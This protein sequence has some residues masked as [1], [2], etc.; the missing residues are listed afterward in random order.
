M[1]SAPPHRPARKAASRPGRRAAQGPAP[2]N[3]A[4]QGGGSHGAFTWGVLDALLEDGS[5]ELAGLSGTSAGAMNAAVLACGLARGGR[6]GAREALRSFWACL[7]GQAQAFGPAPDLPAMNAMNLGGTPGLA[8]FNLDANPFFGWINAWLGLFSPYQFNPLNL[9]TLRDVLSAHVSD[10]ELQNLPTPLYVTATSVRTGQPRVFSG[11][12]LSVDALMASA[13]LPQ[14][15]QAVQ[16]E[17]EPFWDGGFVGNPS[18]WPLFETGVADIVLVQLDPL[19]RKDTP[20]TAVE[21]T[22]RLNEITFNASLTAEMRA[23]HFVQKLAAQGHLPEGYLVPRLHRIA[24]D[25]ALAPLT[26][27]SK[28][29]TDGRFLTELFALG[30]AAAQRWLAGDRRQVGQVQGCDIARVYL[31][32]R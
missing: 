10:V 32:P 22:D 6:D 3:L 15:F 23:I 4:L 16:I 11:Q 17:G 31:D 28:Y 24:D 13:C 7:S 21:I 25:E 12:G 20:D 1:S 30:R 14:L 19:L 18:L 9:N 27:S 2:V 26:A 5:L 8:Q 29:N